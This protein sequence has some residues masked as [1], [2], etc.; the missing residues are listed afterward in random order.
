MSHRGSF[1]LLRIVIGF[2]AAIGLACLGHEAYLFI[3]NWITA[4]AFMHALG[5]GGI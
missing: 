5:E 3:H 1:S 4:I 2:L